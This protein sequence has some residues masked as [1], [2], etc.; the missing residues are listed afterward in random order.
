M[1][2][3]MLKKL[4]KCL[5]CFWAII[6]KDVRNIFRITVISILMP[7]MSAKEVICFG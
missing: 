6:L 7:Q 4:P 1:T 3:T 2:G 5:I